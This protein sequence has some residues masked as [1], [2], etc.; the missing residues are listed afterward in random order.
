MG[1][2]FINPGDNIDTSDL[3]YE[4]V[5]SKYAFNFNY[6][7]NGIFYIKSKG[8]IDDKIF[9]LQ[10]EA[11][12]I[13]RERLKILFPEKKY[14]LIW[15]ITEVFGVSLFGRYL[16]FS[17]L[18]ATPNFGSI[19]LIGSNMLA[20]NF[21]NIISKIVPGI[22][23]SIFR[24]YDEAIT[25]LT[26]TFF[27][28]S[29]QN[30]NEN[31][32]I[33]EKDV[34]YSHFIELWQQQQTLITINNNP[35][36]FYTKPE[37]NVE[38]PDNSFNLNIRIIEGNIIYYTVSGEIKPYHIDKI[39]SILKDIIQ[40]LK[41]SPSNRF[42]SILD[43]KKTVSVSLD[44]RRRTSY[45]EHIYSPYCFRVFAIPN[46]LLKLLIKTI[47]KI[48]VADFNH[49]EITNNVEDAVKTSLD[50]IYNQGKHVEPKIKV[51]EKTAQDQ[52]SIPASKA[53]MIELIH[54]LQSQ[55]IH[56]KEFQ[57]QQVEKILEVTG[58]L[59][60]DESWV[61]SEY[62]TIT[63][64]PFGEVFDSL[65]ILYKDFKDILKEKTSHA[66]QLAES[67]DK[68][69][70]LI[71][72]ANDIIAVFQDSTIRYV[73]SRVTQI[74][75]YKIEEVIGAPMSDFIIPE[76]VP[77]I[78]G[79]YKKRIMGE[80]FPSVYET[81]FLHKAGYAVS[82]SM[83]VGKIMYYNK[84]AVMIIVRD[85]SQKKKIEEELDRYRN[86]LEEIIR[87][88]T[89]QLQKEISERRI[90]EESDR[91]KTAFLSNMS[92]EIR[93]PMNA[94]IAFSDY[95][96]N[97]DLTDAQREE[98]LNYIQ[99]S[100]QSLLN[101]INDI[102]D[103][104]KIESKQIDIQ[105][106]DFNINSLLDELYVLFEEARKKKCKTN[107]ILKLTKPE[108]KHISLH[109]DQ[110]RLK[111]ILSNLIDNAM[112]FT[113]EGYIEFG[114]LLKNKDVVFYVKDSG[115]GIPEDKQDHIFKRFGRVANA[116]RNISGT[117]LGLAISKNLASLLNGKLWVESKIGEGSTFFLR[118]PDYISTKL[119]VPEQKPQPVL[120]NT[121]D[122]GKRKILI[123]EDEDLNFRVLQIA[124][125]RTGATI[126]RANNGREAVE[127]VE[128]NDDIDIVLMDIQMP[129][130]DGY[131]AM[132]KIKQIHK[133][134]PVIAQT[135]FALLE[136]KNRCIEIGF[137]DYIA[138]PIKLDDLFRKVELQFEKKN[139]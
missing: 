92:H 85:I 133:A 9:K 132:S 90:A 115:E 116:N 31:K 3:I 40:E 63:N 78:Q 49:W 96:K 76:E 111:Q 19:S 50:L 37:W 103:L 77:R 48:N 15:D 16:I 42:I 74:L 69:K 136:E 102:I 60:W 71:E 119:D 57:A 80:N 120:M 14:H 1:I 91:L 124:I 127:M 33:Y 81:T 106:S 30:I 62:K 6:L 53:E 8:Y 73:N 65:S 59:T 99:S 117:G 21:M 54:D 112:K 130:M 5:D 89:E 137:D 123:A 97:I 109:T 12:D 27:I 22:K 23:F 46:Y 121:F 134:L 55:I 32:V 94:I 10:L 66:Q 101:L 68:Y 72:L 98:Y 26:H 7:G 20:I 58:R 93:T 39:Y 56:L 64:S 47:S 44:A 86:H 35:L 36:K 131:E 34:T 2:D 125:S 118:I 108:D 139:G 126:L 79:F 104:S 45:Y 88:R 95:L 84:P 105:L 138:K 113:E 110:Y 52:I 129:E 4:R 51:A 67:E 11:G 122:W 135:A 25:S 100:G 128:A 87:K 24:S 43:I 75:G 83:S 107:I 41:F 38:S 13:A 18:K 70:N 61:P 82:V 17:K 114:C 29:V 28:Q